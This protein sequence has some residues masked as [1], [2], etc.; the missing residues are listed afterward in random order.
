M[1]LF[2]VGGRLGRRR[3]DTRHR[4]ARLREAVTL[5]HLDL[6]AIVVGSIVDFETKLGSDNGDVLKQCALNSLIGGPLVVG[7]EYKE[8]EGS[9]MLGGL[10]QSHE[11]ILVLADSVI[12]REI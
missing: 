4:F 8:L 11:H 7:S 2:G 6:K 12:G 10:Q 5:G 1:L 9:T 3:L